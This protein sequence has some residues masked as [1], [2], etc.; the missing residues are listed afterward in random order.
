MFGGFNLSQL[1]PG[2]DV[3]SMLAKMPEQQRTAISDSM[4]EKFASMGETMVVQ[5]AVD[6][7]L[8]EFGAP[9]LRHGRIFRSEHTRVQRHDAPIDERLR[10]LELGRDLLG[11]VPALRLAVGEAGVAADHSLEQQPLPRL[12]LPLPLKP[13]SSRLR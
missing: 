9:P 2:T 3:F 8:L 6:A 4:D 7:A 1:P 13:Q 10:D 5:A 11:D 12:L